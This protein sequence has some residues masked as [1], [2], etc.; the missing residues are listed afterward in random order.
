[1][2]CS[3]QS[4][5]HAS[6]DATFGTT[7]PS[8]AIMALAKPV[9]ATLVQL[10]L[11]EG[12][13]LGLGGVGPSGSQVQQCGFGLQFGEQHGNRSFG[14]NKGG[15]P[16]NRSQPPISVQRDREPG[17][18]HTEDSAVPSPAL[19]STLPQQRNSQIE[20]RLP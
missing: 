16:G 15:S 8:P 20:A 11:F 14:G 12:V 3:K 13:G 9:L 7:A 19:T 10:V 1:M 4:L 5:Q 18:R 17:C 2:P 6:A